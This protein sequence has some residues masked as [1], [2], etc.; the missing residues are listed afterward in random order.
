MIPP[1][2]YFTECVVNLH[3]ST[4]VLLPPDQLHCANKANEE[5]AAA[6]SECH[7][8]LICRRPSLSYDDG[9]KFEKNFGV[10]KFIRKISGKAEAVDFVARLDPA[11]GGDVKVG[12]YPHRELIGLTED[13]REDR[14]WPASFTSLWAKV[15]DPSIKEFEVIYVGQAFG[16]GTRSAIDR[17]K[18]HSTLQRILADSASKRPDDEIMLFLFKYE[19]YMLIA[20]MDGLSGDGEKGQADTDHFNSILENP[21]TEK[22]QVALAEAGLIRYFSPIYNEIYKDSFPHD[23]LKILDECYK[24]DFAGLTVEIN[25]EDVSA[26][27]WSPSV[28]KGL[29]HIANFDLH[30]LGARRSFFSIV[31]KDGRYA[32]MNDSG[33]VF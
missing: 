27:L 23:G 28:G 24:L 21:L 16:D 7:I 6:M 29:H 32:L 9:F 20:S 14:S 17:L 30:D 25:T 5:T 11:D 18:S 1:R 8:Y 19:P 22:Q 3:T 33:P 15:A 13:G 12:P 2:K 26:P 31:D 4:V 10:G